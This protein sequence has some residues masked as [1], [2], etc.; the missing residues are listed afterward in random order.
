M[1]RIDRSEWSRFCEF[2]RSICRG[3]EWLV[4]RGVE[5][6]GQVIIDVLKD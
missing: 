5:L 1:I 6:Y 3:S 2:D 4:S